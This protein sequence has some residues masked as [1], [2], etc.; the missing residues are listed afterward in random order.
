MRLIAI[1]A[2]L[3]AGVAALAQP[4][5]TSTKEVTITP[6][7]DLDTILDAL[8]ARGENLRDFS[9]DVAVHTTDLRTGQ[10]TAQIGKVIFDNRGAG[11]SRIRVSFETKKIDNGNGPPITQK[12][13]LDYVLEKGW[14]TDRDYQ[15][16][17][18]VKRQVLKPDQKMNL[19][20]LGEG[21]FPLPIGQDKDEVKR[22][23]NVT[24]VA[25]AS[26]DPKDTVHLTL[27]PKPDSQ[28]SKRFKQL[29][30][31][32]DTHNNMPTRIDTVEKAG[33]TRSTELSNIKL[34]AGVPNDAFTLTNIDN[35]GW[36]RR[37]EPFE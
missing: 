25:P 11:D 7:S 27:I 29:D 4:A 5:A 26:D 30:V 6:G 8:H 20:K 31:F 28:M 9:A 14:L 36:N 16:K 1:M 2:F 37:E 12:Q 35:Q 13:R 24:T 22:Q 15:K 32:V 33:T 18:E 19:L 34:N 10:D 3:F 23:F 17:L 21:P